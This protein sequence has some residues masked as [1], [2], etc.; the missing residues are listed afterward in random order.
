M[1]PGHLVVACFRKACAPEFLE[2]ALTDLEAMYRVA[3]EF[4]ENVYIS[5]NNAHII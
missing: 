4:Q 1:Q 5:D 2:T 3:V